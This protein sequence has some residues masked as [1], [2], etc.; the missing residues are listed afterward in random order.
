M[1]SFLILSLSLTLLPSLTATHFYVKS[2]FL[3]ETAELLEQTETE[4]RREKAGHEAAHHVLAAN[5]LKLNEVTQ[6]RDN[7]ISRCKALTD[8]HAA[9][10]SSE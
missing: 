3:P 8:Q 2:R 5:I 1:Q 9:D 7:A 4:L 6:E 10:L